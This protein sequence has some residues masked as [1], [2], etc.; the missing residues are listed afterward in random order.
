MKVSQVKKE[1]WNLGL[2]DVSIPI[3]S[4]ETAA[5]QQG[6]SRVSGKVVDQ[7][8]SCSGRHKSKKEQD[9]HKEHFTAWEEKGCPIEGKDRRSCAPHLHRAQ[10]GSGQSGQYGRP[11]VHTKNLG[12]KEAVTVKSGSNTGAEAKDKMTKVGA[13]S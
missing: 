11:M 2:R 3:A 7:W 9:P 10:S 5:Q 8:M 4:G 12:R 13:G 6:G 1:P